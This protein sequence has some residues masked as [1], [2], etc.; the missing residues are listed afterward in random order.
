MIILIPWLSG[1]LLLLIECEHSTCLS[2]KLD[3]LC[4]DCLIFLQ[5]K[6]SNQRVLG[7]QGTGEYKYCELNQE[8]QRQP[9]LVLDCGRREGK[10]RRIT[11]WVKVEDKDGKR[12][13]D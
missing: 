7:R 13:K 4:R 5:G 2:G 6:A 10:T 11:E 8:E 1:I 12:K 9:A 3:F